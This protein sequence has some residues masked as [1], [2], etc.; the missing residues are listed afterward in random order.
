MSENTPIDNENQTTSGSSEG[1]PTVR[2]SNQNVS[3]PAGSGWSEV[4]EDWREVGEEFKKLGV[5]LGGAIRTG[6]RRENDQQLSGLGDQLRAMADQVE[7]AVRAARQE[8]QAPET[9][10]QTQRV[11]AAARGAGT[12]LVDEVR[13]T[14]A[15]GLR[16]LNSQLRELAERI[17]SGR[18]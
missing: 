1:L 10:A 4:T 18:K 8:A 11:V 9:K 17:E 13:D 16:T 2:L 5:R 6:W 3:Q 12:T 15:A 14:V 7:T